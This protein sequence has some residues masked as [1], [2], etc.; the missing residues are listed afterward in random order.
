[1]VLALFFKKWRVCS[2]AA[3][4]QQLG[5]SVKALQQLADAE[6]ATRRAAGRGNPPLSKCNLGKNVGHLRGCL[7]LFSLFWACLL[8]F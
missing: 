7:Q 1:V 4:A 3:A 5:S 2:G 6:E 8:L